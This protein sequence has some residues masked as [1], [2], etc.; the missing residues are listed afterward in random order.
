MLKP[1]GR[2][3]G[4][5]LLAAVL[6]CA[7]L[8]GCNDKSAEEYIRDARKHHDDRQISAAIIDLKNALQQEPK[9]L[10][11]RLLLAQYYLDVP[12]A[13][14]A[15]AEALHAR[16]DGAESQSTAPVLAQAELLL[17]KPDSALKEADPA[18]GTTPE[19]KATLLGLRGQALML[20]GRQ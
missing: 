13:L 16:Q 11:A 19:Q 17:G 1:H 7:L 12:D 10:T 4:M 8:V 9:N 6:G 14:G 3:V 18:N 20:L 2:L 15:E 5:R